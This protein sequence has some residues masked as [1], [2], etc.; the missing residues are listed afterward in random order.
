MTGLGHERFAVAGY[1]PGL[2]VGCAPAASRRERVT[3]PVFAQAILPG[4]SP[5][6]P[7]FM[8]TATNRF[9]WHFAFNRL[10]DIN[11]RTVA[12][13]EEIYFGH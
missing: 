5:S 7:L 4:L 13:R 6:P 1:D 3:R 9:L 2:I 12:G 8:G 11:E 10:P